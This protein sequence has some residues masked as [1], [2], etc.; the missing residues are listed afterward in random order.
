MKSLYILFMHFGLLTFSSLESAPSLPNT[1]T[2]YMKEE[3][4]FQGRLTLKKIF[5]DPAYTKLHMETEYTNGIKT[6]DVYYDSVGNPDFVQGYFESGVVSYSEEYDASGQIKSE[7]QF[8]ANSHLRLEKVYYPNSDVVQKESQFLETGAISLVTFKDES[9]NIFSKRKELDDSVFENTPPAQIIRTPNAQKE[10]WDRANKLL[11]KDI[12]LSISGKPQLV[13]LYD[14]D[15]KK[16]STIQYDLSGTDPSER[17]KSQIYFNVNTATNEK[18]LEVTYTQG[19]KSEEKEFYQNGTTKRRTTFKWFDL[20]NPGA[21]SKTELFDKDGLV[22]HDAFAKSS[23]AVSFSAAPSSKAKDR[24]TSA[25]KKILRSFVPFKNL[26]ADQKNKKEKLNTQQSLQTA[27]LKLQNPSINEADLLDALKTIVRAV[28]IQTTLQI[29]PDEA[30]KILSL[31]QRANDLLLRTN[32]IIITTLF[33]SLPQALVDYQMASPLILHGG[34]EAIANGYTAKGVN[35]F[36]TEIGKTRNQTLDSRPNWTSLAVDGGVV[37]SDHATEVNSLILN[38]LKNKVFAVPHKQWKDIVLFNRSSQSQMDLIT[39]AASKANKFIVN[40]SWGTNLNQDRAIISGILP[41]PGLKI[42]AAGNDAIPLDNSSAKKDSDQR[43]YMSLEPALMSKLILAGAIDHFGN[44]ANFSQTPGRNPTLQERFLCA[45]GVSVEA[46]N[47]ATS[48]SGLATYTQVDGT[49]FSAPIISHAAAI[50]MGAFPSFGEA[51]IADVLLQSGMRTFDINNLSGS[52][53]EHIVENPALVRSSFTDANHVFHTYKSF[54]S[55]K[56]IYG[57]GI[58]SLNRAFALAKLKF[59][60]QN[61]PWDSLLKQIPPDP[62][63]NSW[64]K[65]VT[66]HI[67]SNGIKVE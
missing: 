64:S 26:L 7:R 21:V 43:A 51:E 5:L 60:N 52:A 2:T 41:G 4:D 8:Y 27:I 24:W 57:M 40:A 36:V 34:L 10:Y 55:V 28:N 46:L 48:D 22:M 61:K 44:I 54:S 37:F 6:T 30:K 25:T 39:T 63:F 53:V 3:K 1:Y 59:D 20:K 66:K 67:V 13:T 47:G 23:P 33:H 16:F 17:K 18:H 11:K 62:S 58:L 14:E 32:P 42:I 50:L 45:I 9:G 29:Q 12:V 49:S 19:I 15:G 38:G 65:N 35:V 31:V 56:H